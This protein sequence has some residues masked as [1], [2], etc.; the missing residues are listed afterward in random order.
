MNCMNDLNTSDNRENS[1]RLAHKVI[2]IT[3]AATGIGR[4]VALACAAQGATLILLDH[5]VAL[6]EQLDDQLVQ[7]GLPQPAL[8][9]LDLEG[10]KATDY[11]D[12]AQIIA[13]EFGYL[14]GL[15][16]NAAT[17]GKVTP[18]AHYPPALWQAV[19]QVNVNAPFMLTR[20]FLPL[21]V[22]S[23]PS[24][25]VFTLDYSPQRL[26][27]APGA[28]WGAYAASKAAL[29]GLFATV[30]AEC[31]E[32]P[33]RVNAIYPGIVNTDLRRSVYPGINPQQ[34]TQPAAITTAY[35]ELLSVADPQLRGQVISAQR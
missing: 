24:S 9:P 19:M 2:L 17:L 32:S 7:M 23:G 26:L 10:A 1:G 30:S 6:L 28:Y 13:R 8:Y 4:A 29:G 20:A 31:Q 3:G 33:V 27:G 5:Q 35:I 16:H 12:L 34:W 21:L 14:H 18:L 15:L 11:E 25:L 22:R